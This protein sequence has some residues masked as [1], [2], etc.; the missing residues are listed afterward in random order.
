M[1]IFLLIHILF[2]PV[3]GAKSGV[4]VPQITS[5]SFDSFVRD[6]LVLITFCVKKMPNCKKMM[7]E[8]EK[9]HK[10]VPAVPF[11]TI[12]CIQDQ[13]ICK[14]FNIT[15]VPIL[16]V[17][18]NGEGFEYK[19]PRVGEGLAKSLLFKKLQVDREP[20]IEDG[21]V[22]LTDDNF[23]KFVSKRNLV[24]VEFYAPWCGVCKMFAPLFSRTAKELKSNPPLV[25]VDCTVKATEKLCDTYEVTKYP[26]LK[27]FTN[28][29][30]TVQDL[31]LQD[32]EKWKEEV[33][34]DK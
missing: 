22:I 24:L 15:A 23:R 7:V 25:K 10:L 27:I 34:S 2:L 11:G 19:G 16:F 17:F 9:A 12:D 33:S 3:F 13:A 6:D 1:R 32:F 31:R 29:G 5:K 4:T 20:Q 8:L 18:R 14:R 26:T 30:D 28:G 21:V